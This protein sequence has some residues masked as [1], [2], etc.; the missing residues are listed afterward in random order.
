MSFKYGIVCVVLFI[1]IL[2]LAIKSYDALTHRLE[3]VADQGAAKKSETR[4]GNSSVMAVAKEPVSM[5]SYL[6]IGEKNIFNPERKDFS[7]TGAGAGMKPFV[8][9]QVV[10]YGVT[11]AGDY[12]SASVVNPGRP[13]KKGERDLLTLRLGERIGEYK[14]AKV[15]SDRITLEAPG[16]IFEVL[17]YDPKAP[18]RR[19]GG[20]TGTPSSV[21]APTGVPRSPFRREAAERSKEPA[22]QNIIAS[23]LP[24]PAM[25]P[26]GPSQIPGPAPTPGQIPS[27]MMPAPMAPSVTPMPLTPVP[28][29]GQ[30][31]PLPSTT[32]TPPPS[33]GG[34]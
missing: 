15:L 34:K 13:L 2:F 16:D 19:E 6:S 23:Q 25:P 32:P 21:S 20:F 22:R 4:P 28:G 10:L 14:L 9:P 24:M 27:S 1:T 11:I 12:Q 17:L 18:K 3:P 31:I 30:P 26:L 8:R 5:A 7:V 33:P 29:M